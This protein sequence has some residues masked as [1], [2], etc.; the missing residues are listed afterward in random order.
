LLNEETLLGDG[1]AQVVDYELTIRPARYTAKS[2][3]TYDNISFHI[4]TYF[5]YQGEVETLLNNIAAA[6]GLDS[7]RIQ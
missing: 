1:S 6:A 3:V 7:V 5:G 4:I 2:E